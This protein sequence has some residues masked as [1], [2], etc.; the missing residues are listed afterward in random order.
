MVSEIDDVDLDVYIRYYGKIK[1]SWI[2]QRGLSLI[3]NG[4][5]V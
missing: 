3:G 1:L 2:L 5:V 4:V